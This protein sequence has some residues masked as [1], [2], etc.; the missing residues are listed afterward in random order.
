MTARGFNYLALSIMFSTGAPIESSRMSSRIVCRSVRLLTHF[1]E[2]VISRLTHAILHPGSGP[3]SSL[4][5]GSLRPSFAVESGQRRIEFRAMRQKLPI[6][7]VKRELNYTVT[8]AETRWPAEES[9]EPLVMC[10]CRRNEPL[11]DFDEEEWQILRFDLLMPSK[12][13]NG[14]QGPACLL[15]AIVACNRVD[16]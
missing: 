9:T 4:D 2:C 6:G 15:P 8:V 10:K 11:P 7:Q 14:V 1:L 12:S 3:G 5:S 16:Q 13:H